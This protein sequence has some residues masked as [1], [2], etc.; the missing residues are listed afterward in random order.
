MQIRVTEQRSKVY[1]NRNHFSV[2]LQED[3]TLCQNIFIDYA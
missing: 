2:V 3:L 1:M